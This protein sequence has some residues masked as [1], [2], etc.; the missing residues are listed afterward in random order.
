MVVPRERFR[1][2]TLRRPA[3]PFVL[4][5]MVALI[6]IVPLLESLTQPRVGVILGLAIPVLAVAAATVPEGL[7]GVA[8]TTVLLAV[9]VAKLLGRGEAA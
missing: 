3:F 9:L 8:F 2:G 4:G 1:G 5:M 6:V 7:V